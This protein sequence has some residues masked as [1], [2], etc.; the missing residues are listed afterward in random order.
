MR[1]EGAGFFGL[2]APDREGFGMRKM[3]VVL[4]ST[5]LAI[6]MLFFGTYVGPAASMRKARAQTAPPQPNIVFILT[7]DMRKDDLQYMPKTRALLQSEGMT[8]QNA[9]VSN[10]ICAPS[11]STIMRGQYSHNSGVWTN[12]GWP[13]YVSAGD[14]RDDVATRLQAAGYTTGLFGKYLN[15]YGGT[16]DIPAGW[17]RWFAA[18]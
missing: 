4:A 11:R 3:G 9:F 13:T 16:T 17:D 14:E 12:S 5:A 18:L 10:A 7:D 8:F 2:C 15:H 1:R 6:G